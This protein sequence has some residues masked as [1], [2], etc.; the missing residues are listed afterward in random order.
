MYFPG[1]EE[2][3]LESGL[4]ARA[5]DQEQADRRVTLKFVVNTS[6][7][8]EAGIYSSMIC[9]P[10]TRIDTHSSR[11]TMTSPSVRARTMSVIPLTA[12]IHRRRLHVRLSATNGHQYRC[13]R[14]AGNA[15]IGEEPHHSLDA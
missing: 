15:R 7:R 2:V 1:L 5:F 9:A 12:D 4:T 8:G 14:G 13:P 10:I 11:P 3:C 6:V